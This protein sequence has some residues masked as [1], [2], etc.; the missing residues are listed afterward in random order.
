MY[1]CL[2]ACPWV[3]FTIVWLMW[4]CYVL[5]S[6]PRPRPLPSSRGLKLATLFLFLVQAVSD[7]QLPVRCFRLWDGIVAG[8]VRT[9]K[10]FYNLSA[11][12][13]IWL[14]IPIFLFGIVSRDRGLPLYTTTLGAWASLLMSGWPCRWLAPTCL[15]CGNPRCCRLQN[16]SDLELSACLSLGLS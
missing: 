1:S 8:W 9:N 16:V 11:S 14:C 4:L 12:P 15:I 13:N 6:R 2:S 5:L 10:G 7:L 3:Y